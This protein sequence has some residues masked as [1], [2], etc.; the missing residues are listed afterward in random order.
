MRLTSRGNIGG[1]AKGLAHM[2]VAIVA[3]VHGNL[4]ALGAVLADID[5]AGGVDEHWFLG[6]AADLRYDPVGAVRRIRALPGLRTVRGNADRES[7]THPH[8]LDA[9]FAE[10]IAT[11]VV[12]ARTALAIRDNCFWTRGALTQSGQFAWL[13][14]L[15]VEERISLPDGTRVLLVHAAPGTDEGVG[16]RGDHGDEEVEALLDGVQAT[17]VIVGHT[18]RPLGRS[19]GRSTECGY[20]I[21]AV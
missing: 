16:I 5:R 10:L 17:L 1:Y 6:D 7:T 2:R 20:G 11:D 9:E 19:A 14:E 3:D 18:H 21:R 4:L 12:A 13:A 8:E 15:P